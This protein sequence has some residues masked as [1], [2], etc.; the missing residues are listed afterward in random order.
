MQQ[1]EYKDLTIAQAGALWLEMRRPFLKD[2]TQQHYEYCIGSLARFFPGKKIGD[3][4]MGNILHYQA[5]RRK[6][7]ERQVKL[8]GGKVVAK[9]LR[10]NVRVVNHEMGTLCQIMRRA[11]PETYA[12]KIKPFYKPLPLP[13]WEP[14]KVVTQEE[15]DRFFQVAHKNVFEKKNADRLVAYCAASIM[16]NTGIRGGELRG[17]KLQDIDWEKGLIFVPPRLAKNKGSV[18][19]VALNEKALKHLQYLKIAA[20]ER[21]S[22][23]QEHHLIPFRIKRNHYDP[24]RPTTGWRTAWRTMVADAELPKNLTPHC[25]R[26]QFI[27]KGLENPNISE[28]TMM[29]QVG[30]IRREM[31]DHYS[32]TRIAAKKAAVSLLEPVVPDG[33]PVS[34]TKDVADLFTEKAKAARKKA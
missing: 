10:A 18:R 19:K 33:K 1:N 20:L 27:T 32:H 21:G 9:Q 29:A 28:Q 31:L 4:D 16:V 22:Y 13:K 11:C 6:L 23:L 8:R 17:L 30:H 7:T 26:H 34:G 12:T 5:E 15:E 2:K 25:L 3:V 24:T 14:P